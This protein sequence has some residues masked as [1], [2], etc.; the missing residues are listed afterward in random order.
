MALAEGVL[1]EI[2]TVVTQAAVRAI[3]SGEESIRVETLENL[4]FLPPTERRH[5]AE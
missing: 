1:G 2:T 4:G 3:T 5:A